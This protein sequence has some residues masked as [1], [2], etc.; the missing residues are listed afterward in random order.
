[1]AEKILW[2][3]APLPLVVA[4]AS[5]LAFAAK[6]NFN[7]APSSSMLSACSTTTPFFFVE[8]DDESGAGLYC[9]KG[10][11]PN[12]IIWRYNKPDSLVSSNIVLPPDNDGAY[13]TIKC[14]FDN[15]K[16]NG[17]NALRNTQ[18][19]NCSTT[20]TA[21]PTPTPSPLPVPTPTP[22][23]PVVAAKQGTASPILSINMGAS[24]QNGAGGSGGTANASRHTSPDC[25][26]HCAS[27]LLMPGGSRAILSSGCGVNLRALR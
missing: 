5:D 13:Y 26:H 16:G 9:Q 11:K 4:C 27:F 10:S 8:H 17:S 12:T 19:I 24:G 20:K 18:I 6:M 15:G 21:G 2:A 22:L 3:L 1:M 14:S 7:I 23:P 25:H